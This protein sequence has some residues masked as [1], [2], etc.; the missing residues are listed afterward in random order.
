MGRLFRLSIYVGLLLLLGLGA[1]WAVAY[2]AVGSMLGAPPPKMGAQKTVLALGGAKQLKGH[3]PAWIFS[4][5]PTVI[6][7]AERAVIY[8][9]LFGKV[10]R[11]DPPDLAK[12]VEAFQTYH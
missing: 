10:I 2:F 12:R 7:G 9:N 11:T 3:P 6:P 4:F 8:V 1:S 5:G